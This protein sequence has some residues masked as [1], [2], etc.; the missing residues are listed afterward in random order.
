MMMGGIKMSYIERF[1]Q[2]QNY[3]RY[4]LNGLMIVFELIV[5]SNFLT[6]GVT[7]RN[8]LAISLAILINDSIIHA[9]FWFAPEPIRWRD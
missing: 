1:F 6:G 4:L 5:F 7:I 9:I 2:W 3:V 8:I